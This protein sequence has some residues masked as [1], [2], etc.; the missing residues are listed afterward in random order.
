MT[1]MHHI[2]SKKTKSV[3]DTETDSFTPGTDSTTLIHWPKDRLPEV[4]E[5]D[6]G[7]FPDNLVRGRT[8]FLQ[9]TRCCVE[10]W[11]CPPQDVHRDIEDT[12]N[13]CVYP[14]G[15]TNPEGHFPDV[16]VRGKST[17]LRDTRCCVAKWLCPPQDFREATVE[18]N[19]IR[20]VNTPSI[21]RLQDRIFKNKVN[22]QTAQLFFAESRSTCDLTGKKCCNS[23]RPQDLF[24][25]RNSFTIFGVEYGFP[26]PWPQDR[27]P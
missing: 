2:L 14:P 16:S 23:P 24:P 6:T 17:F 13:L 26:L 22:D 20:L 9:D 3:D 4:T 10:N 19:K 25:N 1:F 11:L 18:I 8:T 15:E 12:A 5:L 21:P 7:Y 27:P